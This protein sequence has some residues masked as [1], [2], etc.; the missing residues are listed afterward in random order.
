[1]KKVLL[2]FFSITTMSY[3]SFSQ[4]KTPEIVENN[5]YTDLG[6]DILSSY[7]WRGLKIDAA[8][9]IQGWGEFGI[10]GFNFGVWASTNF[11]GSFAETDIYAGYS[12]G[13]LN[14]TVTNYFTGN[15]SF[16]SFNKAEIQHV[17]EL[18]MEYTLSKKFPLKITAGTLFYGDDYKIDSYDINGDPVFNETRNYSTYFEF[19]YPFTHAETEIAVVLGGVAHESAFYES[20]GAAIIN[21]G[22]KVS[23][24]LKVTDYFKLPVSFGVTVNPATE[25][26]YSIFNI[27]L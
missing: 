11:T 7:I 25:S 16:F 20:D 24:E 8:P 5:S 2:V 10:A 6:A 12:I 21:I 1:M 27:S 22:A 19:M 17:G 18:T 13:N 4:E 9:N 15:S 3:F 23:K 26:I 14:T